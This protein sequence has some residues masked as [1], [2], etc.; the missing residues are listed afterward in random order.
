[1]LLGSEQHEGRLA[2]SAARW[3]RSS[4]AAFRSR[5]ADCQHGLVLGFLEHVNYNILQLG[6]QHVETISQRELAVQVMATNSNKIYR[7][8]DPTS[9]NHRVEVWWQRKRRDR[10]RQT[11]NEAIR[12]QLLMGTNETS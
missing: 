1:M 11:C 12:G 10:D 8:K 3:S 4:D 9:E 2:L 6:L 7:K 5:H